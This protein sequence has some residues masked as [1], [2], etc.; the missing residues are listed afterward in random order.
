MMGSPG[1]IDYIVIITIVL[2]V[3]ACGFYCFFAY[4]IGIIAIIICAI[5]IDQSMCRVSLIKHLKYISLTKV[6][7][8][9]RTRV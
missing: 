8:L 1:N 7:E 4:T 6:G 3:G 9:A 2:M 5:G